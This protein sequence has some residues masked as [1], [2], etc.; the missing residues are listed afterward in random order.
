MT[1][2][3]HSS[4]LLAPLAA[5]LIPNLKIKAVSSV[6]KLVTTNR[7]THRRNQEVDSLLLH[8]NF[9]PCTRGGNL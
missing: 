8:A 6:E 5:W 1:W 7:T 2:S 4:V 3:F 9:M